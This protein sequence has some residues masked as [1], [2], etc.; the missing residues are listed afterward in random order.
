VKTVD[1]LYQDI[2][3]FENLYLAYRKAAKGKRGQPNVAAFEFDLEANLFQLQSEL[4][5]KRY[6]PGP[7]HSFRIYDPKPRLISAAPFRDRV[8]HHALCNVIEPIFER[9][10]IGDSYANRVG[11][12]THA[13]L[14]RCQTFARRYRYVLQ[15]DIRQFFPSLDLDILRAIL[16]RKIAD[17]DVMWLVDRI[18]ESGAGILTDEYQVIYFPG[19]DLFAAVRVR[20]LP[21]GNLTSQFWANVYLNELD[22]FVKRELH[23]SAHLRYVDDFLL[24]HD[25]KRQLW[26]WKDAVRDFLADRRLT[27]HERESTVYPVTNG[28]PFLGFRIY[29]THRRLKRRNGVAFARRFHRWREAIGRGDMGLEELHRRVQGWVA[30]AAHGDTRALRRSLLAV[31]IPVSPVP[32]VTSRSS[33]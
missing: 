6:R 11:K 25:S 31:T 7:Y 13:A 5:D 19:D 28:I 33:S 8:V 1:N 20:G 27:L 22:Q 2:V 32:N 14:D 3:A 21:I 29:P 24:F 12:G 15:C 9:T 10:F 17:K 30:H 4:R 16:A 26:D 18:L 23:C